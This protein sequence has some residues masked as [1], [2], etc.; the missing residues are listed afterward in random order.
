[1]PRLTQTFG[2]G[3]L[4]P[5][6]GSPPKKLSRSFVFLFNSIIVKQKKIS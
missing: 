2:L 1:M 5:L 6:G 3:F 4:I